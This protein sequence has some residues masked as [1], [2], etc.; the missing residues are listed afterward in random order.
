MS[1]LTCL[2]L[3]QRQRRRMVAAYAPATGG[4]RDDPGLARPVFWYARLR[5]FLTCQ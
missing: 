4:R 1:I 2:Q 3:G 5:M